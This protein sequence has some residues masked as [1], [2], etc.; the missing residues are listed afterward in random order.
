MRPNHAAYFGVDRKGVLSVCCSRGLVPT[1][2]TG[3]R[4]DLTTLIFTQRAT[5]RDIGSNTSAVSCKR[6]TST[7]TL[8]AFNVVM[9]FNM[10]L[11]M[12]SF[13]PALQ[14]GRLNNEVN[15][16]HVCSTTTYPAP[17]R[18]TQWLLAQVLSSQ[19]QKSSSSYG[20]PDDGRNELFS[21]LCYVFSLTGPAT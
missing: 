13:L 5:S 12:S 7:L 2:S 19:T 3:E 14:N 20:S 17:V 11:D 8:K 16:S 10:L 21:M 4:P 6:G 9:N 18:H 15:P 1:W